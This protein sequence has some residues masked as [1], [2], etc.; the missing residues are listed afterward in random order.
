MSGDN[1]NTYFDSL[2]ELEQS[3]QSN[4]EV[5]Q[6]TL[7]SLKKITDDSA[8]D[9]VLLKTMEQLRK[10]YDGLLGSTAELRYFKFQTREH[11]MSNENRLEIKNREFIIG[12]RHLPNIKEYV[13]CVEDINRD[14]L[15]YINLLNRLSVELTKQVDISDPNVTE[16]VIDKWNPPAELQ[17]ILDNYSNPNVEA[18]DLNAEFQNYLNKIKLSRA[19]YSLENKYLLQSHLAE[20]NKEANYWRKELDNIEMMMFGDGPNSIRKMLQNVD[21]LKAKLIAE[22]QKD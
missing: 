18:D 2:C 1:E 3:L 8:S 14:S 15:E 10:E 20:L 9:A 13:T 7:Q 5:L 22:K 11:Q 6:N 19:K 17:Q 21:S 12:P 16:F 4:H